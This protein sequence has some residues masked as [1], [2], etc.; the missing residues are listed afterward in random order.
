MKT[1]S[2]LLV[3]SSLAWLGDVVDLRIEHDG[4]RWRQKLSGVLLCADTT[5]RVLWLI[6][7][8]K[9]RKTAPLAGQKAAA[10]VYRSW[11]QLAPAEAFAV[12]VT[13]KPPRLVGLVA[14][15]GYRSDKWTGKSA[16]YEHDFKTPPELHQAGRI[17]R[18]RG[19]SVRVTAA[20]ITG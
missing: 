8:P 9:R 12:P 20:G 17:Y 4:R 5:K 1:A 16:V 13:E 7:A 11:A 10:S 15:I 19:D 14:S 18:I 3:P 6:P 2:R